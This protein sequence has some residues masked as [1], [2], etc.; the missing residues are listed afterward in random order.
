MKILVVDDNVDS[1]D[2]L[3]LLLSIG[4]HETH[5]AHD[6][7]G[8]MDAAARLLP[9]VVLLDI[10]L[11]KM[12]GLEVC[13]RIRQ[14]PWGRRMGIVAL[15]GLGQDSD[16]VESESAGFDR[17][18]VKPIDYEALLRTLDTLFLPRS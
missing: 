8:A 14:E 18:V 5:V 16:R 12:D 15:T 6:G 9:D 2:S 10:G 4:G 11:P 3:A 1:A 17:H 7:P 13:R